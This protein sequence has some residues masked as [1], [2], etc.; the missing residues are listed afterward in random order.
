MP[1]AM[2]KMKGLVLL[3]IAVVLSFSL[4]P[5]AFAEQTSLGGGSAGTVALCLAMAA[6]YGGS[7][8]H[9]Q[10]TSRQMSFHWGTGTT[11]T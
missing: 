5:S 4:W 2:K 1:P 8:K 3:A 9:S 10:E 11:I 6:I 7:W